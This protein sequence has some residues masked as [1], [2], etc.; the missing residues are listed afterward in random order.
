MLHGQIHIDTSA[1]YWPL[2]LLRNHVLNA[3]VDINNF[4]PVS[5]GELVINNIIWK[6]D[7]VI[8]KLGDD[9]ES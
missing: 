1:E 7:S 4:E 8:V 9:N 2:L 3:G 6:G 5:F